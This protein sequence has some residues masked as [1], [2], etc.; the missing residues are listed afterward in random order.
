M[1]RWKARGGDKTQATHPE[2]A[3]DADNGLGE[4]S[5]RFCQ[6][7]PDRHLIFATFTVSKGT[8]VMIHPTSQGEVAVYP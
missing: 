7:G 1:G 6:V 3:P 5:L 8:S 2:P 4:I